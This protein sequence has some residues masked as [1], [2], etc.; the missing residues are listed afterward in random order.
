MANLDFQRR[1]SEK[2]SFS[3]IISPKRRGRTW[4]TKVGD[5]RFFFEFHIRILKV[6]SC[7]KKYV[8]L[9]IRGPYLLKHPEMHSMCRK[10]GEVYVVKRERSK[11]NNFE[12][13]R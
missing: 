9:E 4:A 7:R 5:P 8:G 6:I 1:F 11:Y 10:D 12:I 3:L 2:S 13:L